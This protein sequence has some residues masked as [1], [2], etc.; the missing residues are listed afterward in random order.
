METTDGG[1]SH[2]LPQPVTLRLPTEQSYFNE[3]KQFTCAW[4]PEADN[5]FVVP[6]IDR[7]IDPVF[8]D[9]RVS[10]RLS[11]SVLVIPVDEDDKSP[12]RQREPATIRF[13]Q[14]SRYSA[15]NVIRDAELQQAVV[16]PD[17]WYF[18]DPISQ[19]CPRGKELARKENWARF[20]RKYSR[21]EISR[22]LSYLIVEE[23]MPDWYLMGR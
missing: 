19:Q 8:T 3:E 13:S 16:L 4:T 14:L 21:D 17:R 15:A 7:S 18:H 23:F 6:R 11:T 10:P 2:V 1:G 20:N 5:G 22:D 12:E 9:A